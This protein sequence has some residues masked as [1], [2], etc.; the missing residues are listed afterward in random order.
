M[1]RLH[2]FLR[3]PTSESV[4]ERD[5]GPG[6]GVT[7]R[8]NVIQRQWPHARIPLHRTRSHLGKAHRQCG[9]VVR[10]PGESLPHLRALGLPRR[11]L[12]PELPHTIQPGLPHTMRQLDGKM[13]TTGERR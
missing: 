5:E 9:Q 11:L 10:L 1:V 8:G 13:R 6:G 12:Q 3:P 4:H 7:L 2:T